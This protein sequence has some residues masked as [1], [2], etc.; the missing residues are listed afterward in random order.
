MSTHPQKMEIRSISNLNSRFR[1]PAYQRG[2]RWERRHVRQLLDDLLEHIN[3]NNYNVNNRIPYYL[4]PIVVAPLSLNENPDEKSIPYDYDLI[5]GQQ[6]LT[7]IYIILKALKE[8]QANHPDRTQLNNLDFNASYTIAYAT[9]SDSAY[10]LD[11]LDKDTIAWGN[12]RNDC[13]LSKIA[14]TYPDFLYMWHAYQQ[15]K[16]WI[17]DHGDDLSKLGDALLNDVKIIW[18]EL[19]ESVESWEKFTQ[20]NVGKIPLTNS[21]LVK[22]L[23]LSD[24]HQDIDDYERSIIVN[25]WDMVEKEL[26]DNRFLGFL[27]KTPPQIPRI[28]F[29]FDLFAGKPAGNKDDFFTFQHFVDRLNNDRNLKGKALWDDIYSKYLRLK[30]W[31]NDSW[32][33]HRI[34]YLVAIDST[35]NAL[36]SIFTFA[37]PDETNRIE[38]TKKE[39]RAE[40]DERIKKSLEW[41]DVDSVWSLS[42]D[43]KESEEYQKK[44]G[45]P[46]NPKII[47]LLTLYNVMIY[48]KLNA[49]YGVK[50]PF[51]S[52]NNV[53]GGWSLEHIHAQ[54]SER[55]NRSEQWIEWVNDHLDSLKR[56]RKFLDIDRSKDDAMISNWDRLEDE[57][58]RFENSPN[59]DWFD[60]IV[61]SYSK[62]TA[63]SDPR[64]SGEYKDEL[65]NMALLSRDGNS[66]L[67]NST[68]DVKRVIVGEH[69]STDFLPLGTERVFLKSISGKLT[70]ADNANLEYRCDIGHIYYWGE[71]DRDAYKYDI[72]N[73]LKD[74]LNP[75]NDPTKN[76]EPNSNNDEQ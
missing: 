62:L 56:I 70:T 19:N 47:N 35:G 2:Y 21:E 57:M 6:R 37:Y 17:N 50:Y 58:M 66:R 9:R 54:H 29:I 24:Q 18:Y 71:K 25:Q 38:R 65:T 49:T 3:D 75:S 26:S 61:A 45:A 7:T 31:Y 44:S 68:F 63:S 46:H 16:K 64:T 20:L 36:R 4:Q 55:L 69:I 22:A 40:I 74:Y 15:A 51:N 8:F 41:P 10:F 5:D 34:G 67:N 14:Q 59:G 39:L 13:D 11:N 30:D 72:W 76:T 27:T 1:I 52:H 43:D 32:Y 12:P 60:A 73:Y 23:L 42:Y 28:D 53:S 48:D 33:Y